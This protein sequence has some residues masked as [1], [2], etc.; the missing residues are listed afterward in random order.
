MLLDYNRYKPLYC[1]FGKVIGQN[2]QKGEQRYK[3]AGCKKV[4]GSIENKIFVKKY[5]Y[6]QN[7]LDKRG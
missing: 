1:V 5:K 2:R 7:L 3:G 4:G 6:G